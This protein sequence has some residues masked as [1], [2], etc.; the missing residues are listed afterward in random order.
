MG[1]AGEIS[2]NR[3]YISNRGVGFKCTERNTARPMVDL[4]GRQYGTTGLTTQI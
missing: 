1:D 3:T 4:S 2:R